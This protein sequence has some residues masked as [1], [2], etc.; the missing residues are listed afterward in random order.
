MAGLTFKNPDEPTYCPKQ[1][2]LAKI[3]DADGSVY[4]NNEGFIMNGIYLMMARLAY[5]RRYVRVH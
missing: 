2:F 5:R 4:G 3:W 1:N